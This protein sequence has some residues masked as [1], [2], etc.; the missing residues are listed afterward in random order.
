MLSVMREENGGVVFMGL[1][2]KQ[3]HF[4]LSFEIFFTL[5]P[6]C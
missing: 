2:Q 5:Y 3:S 4:F 1:N 6:I